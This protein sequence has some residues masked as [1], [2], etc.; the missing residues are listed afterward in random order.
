MEQPARS[1]EAPAAAPVAAVDEARRLFRA[2]EA[3]ESAS[4]RGRYIAGLSAFLEYVEAHRPD[5]SDAASEVARDIDAA[6]MA[7]YRLD[8]ADLAARSADVGLLYAPRS[9]PLLH[10]KALILLTTNRDVES[11]VPLLEQASEADPQDKA[12]WAA[13]G[14]AFRRT[15]QIKEAAGAF[16]RAQQLDLT[17]T[18]Y[19][20]KALEIDPSSPGALRMRLELAKAH[21]GDR[22]ALQA[23]EKLLEHYP[24]DPA[25]LLARVELLSALGE[26]EPAVAAAAA[27][28]AALP[29]DPHLA[30][31]VG[32]LERTL[33]HADRALEEYRVAARE[34]ARLPVSEL[35]QLAEQVE[36]T[37]SADDLAVEVRQS[38]RAREPRNL[39]NL[40]A[41]RAL[42]GRTHRPD[43]GIAACLGILEVSPGNLE[44][45]RALAEFQI[46]KG[47][48][49]DGFAT[50]RTLV[51]SHPH[52]TAEIRKAIDAA[53]AAGRFALVAEF[54]RAAV[55]SDPSDVGARE[56]LGQALSHSGELEAS[57]EVYNSLTEAQP[58][59]LAFALERK[60]LLA[61]LG[62]T[63][64]LPA[65]HDQL[66]RLDPSRSDVAFER[67][68]LYLAM[69]RERPSGSPER[70]EA[71][72]TAL[73]SFERASSDP[74]LSD[75]SLIGLARA[76]HLRGDTARSVRSY[77]EYLGRPVHEGEGLVWEE[78]GHLLSAS[79]Q[80][81][82]A[83]KAYDR[84][85][86]LGCEDSELLWGQ[87]DVL[88]ALNRESKG[89]RLL[90]AL[91]KRE[92]TNPVYLRKKGL[93]MLKAGHRA[94]GVRLLKSSTE[95][96]HADPQGEFDV[97]AALCTDGAYTD[98]IEYYHRGLALAPKSRPGR[99]ALSETLN[100]AGRYNEAI[101]VVDALLVEDSNDLA[102]WKVRADACRALGRRADLEYSLRAILLI[103]P[104]HTPALLEKYRL[105]LSQG[106][107]TEAH[108]CL[109][110]FLGASGNGG[111][112]PALLLE[113]GDL[114][115][116]L[117]RTEEAS[118]AFERAGE[119]DPKLRS[120]AAVRRARLEL[121][122]GR[123]DRALE[124]LDDG[125]KAGPPPPSE[126]E[127]VAL[128]RAEILMGLERAPEAEAIYRAAV[129][130]RPDS[131]QATLGLARALLD[132]GKHADAK[133][134]L[135][136]AIP[137][138]PP[139]ETLY[140]LLAEAQSGLGAIPEAVA[141]AR[142]GVEALPTSTLLWKRLGELEMARE[143][144]SDAS[145][146]FAR[147]IA[148]DATNSELLLKAGF[149][150]DKLGHSM[151]SLA[152]YDRATQVAPADKYAW[153][154]RGL[155]LLAAG[156]AE[157]AS[158]SFE[159][160][161]AL[162]PEFDAAQQGKKASSEKARELEIDR[163]GREALRLEAK[164]HRSVTKSDLFVTLHVPYDLLDPIL[165]ALSRDTRIDLP[166][167]SEEEMRQ[168]ERDS[169]QLVTAALDRRADG[170][171]RRGFTLADVAVLSPPTRSLVE[172]QR[173][174]G[175]LRAVLEADL[176]P[177]NIQLTP[178]VEELAR[179]ALLL[180]PAQRTLFEIARTM[181]VG[182]F[183]ARLIKTVEAAGATVH[184]PL[185]TLDL[186]AYTP[187]FRA[188]P[189]PA[190]W[191]GRAD[192]RPPP[193]GPGGGRG[194]VEVLEPARATPEAPAGPA[195]AHPRCIGCGG[196]A[197][198][199]HSCGAPVCAHCIVEFRTCPKCHLAID[200]PPPPPPPSPP[201]EEPEGAYADG[202]RGMSHGGR[203]APSRPKP[204]KVRDLAEERAAALAARERSAPPAAA[205][206]PAEA[207]PRP[208]R[209]K[210]KPD[211]EPR[212]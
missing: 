4:D 147:A 171:E 160:A 115:Q 48:P 31:L 176:R 76:S 207:P 28:R 32:H 190:A 205:A 44:A 111:A 18:Q 169:C 54:A 156:R 43:L 2:S 191:P 52:E 40:H 84:A 102:A 124:V 66:F 42:A 170:V 210:E 114:A 133:S 50:Y 167:L 94:E 146:A 21:G 46:A 203:P 20:D 17:S 88:A 198:V 181:H 130:A 131:S 8:Q 163:L 141:A 55:E 193:T 151:D 162:D 104:S 144:W 13:L 7:F 73:V 105:H 30:L 172:T 110:Q 145:V 166:K 134:A 69:A 199:I 143:A 72:G 132:Q 125:L 153:S 159:R 164:L 100:L 91:L 154:S 58:D 120:T 212:L 67:G 60:R 149:I 65:I 27:A 116:E 1:N 56:S 197:T 118:R 148:L 63:A 183:K 64:S 98:A 106:E 38:L 53:A 136:E 24:D 161:L 83:E 108:D 86:A 187:E 155:A 80:W 85:L 61:E 165:A 175:Y 77:R 113:A 129:R 87:V 168:L 194:A 10:H 6:T 101:P 107:K 11:A 182:V 121:G 45:M 142:R 89:L 15:G 9:A 82:E 90:D 117:G 49:D 177:E 185:P 157:D 25:L 126:A 184:A 188:P 152:F 209:P 5:L 192:V 135:D 174:F 29:D 103:D 23:C 96:A 39:A 12:I 180:P 195:H 173:L 19:L 139:A 122:A 196:L 59:N 109:A 35:V 51:Q 186:G 137:H 95:Q 127:A 201:G 14:E 47:S 119:L 189:T 123:P 41:L 204:P 37:K 178:D 206:A 34:S 68:E 128:L 33:G 22:P 57:L 140:L 74:A 99:L 112:D 78:F 202:G 92:P 150:A 71:A 200:L 208:V 3:A 179:R 138:L 79:G 70:A 26:I 211:D 97:A 16:L 75:R 158:A 81:T 93:L 36:S 62:R